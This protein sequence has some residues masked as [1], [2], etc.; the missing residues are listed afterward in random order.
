MLGTLSTLVTKVH[1]LMIL[2]D[3]E[4]V[5][6]KE[7]RLERF[8]RI[9]GVHPVGVVERLVLNLMLIGKAKKIHS[10]ASVHL[11]KISY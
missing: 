5:V 6:L 11:Q 4:Q 7:L 10:F 1:Q 8:F 3:S 9:I 2:L